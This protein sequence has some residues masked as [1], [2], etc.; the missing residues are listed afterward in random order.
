MTKITCNEQNIIFGKFVKIIHVGPDS[1]FIQFISEVFEAAA[2]GASQYLVTGTSIPGKLRFPVSSGALSISVSGKRGAASIPLHVH[3]CD[4]VIAHG[5]G[6]HGIVAFLAS[7]R[8]ATKVWSGWG[9]DY[10]GDEKD[11]NANLLSPATKELMRDEY[12]DKNKPSA[13][14][15]ISRKILSSGINKA[16]EITNYFSAPIPHDF[17]IFKQRFPN[18][19]GKYAQ[20]NYGSVIDTFSQGMRMGHGTNILVGNSASESNNHID[21]F[22]I[23]AKHDIGLR[24]VIVPLSYG[25]SSYRRNIINAGKQILGNSFS[26]LVDF[27]PLDQYSSIIAS[28]NIVIMNHLRQQALGNIGTAIYQGAHVFLNPRN[29]AYIFFKEKDAT[30]RSTAEL[31]INNL[32]MTSLSN[33]QVIKNRAVLNSFWSHEKVRSNV[34]FLLSNARIG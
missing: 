24:K 2:P 21:I 27:L 31:L 23:L 8:K 13:I 4:M 16:S 28:C 34:D 11:P 5:M 26:P 22:K 15:K 18:F 33:S 20:L 32:P 9:F 25:D 19:S 3:A 10:Y 6:L 7:P 17:E 14:K 1:Q 29:P 30:I 12:A